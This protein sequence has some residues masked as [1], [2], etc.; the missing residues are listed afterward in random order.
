MVRLV[1]I[2][3]IHLSRRRAYFLDNWN[4]VVDHLAK[5]PP[6]LVVLTGDVSFNGSD[7]DDDL[8]FARAE[9][10]R[11]PCPTLVL[12]GN[13]DIGEHPLSGKNDQPIDT[14]RHGRWMRHFASDRFIVDVD[15]WTLIG[16][17]SELFGSGLTVE[18]EQWAWLE[19]E[20]AARTGHRMALFMHRPAF[21]L[22][23]GEAANYNSFIDP[24]PRL[25]LLNLVHKYRVRILAS[26]HLHAYRRLSH[27]GTDF[28]WAPG[29]SFVVANRRAELDVLNRSAILE[30]R[31]EAGGVN[32]FL[33]EPARLINLDFS[34]WFRG[35]ASTVQLPPLIAR[36]S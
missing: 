5:D 28:V 25:R 33:V 18:D 17:N 13:H 26:G 6:D 4:V 2:S 36:P 35:A 14:I 20:L 11:L 22:A 10:D 31:F 9:I 29:T 21:A 1:Q 8:A 23:P 27:A 12:P 34:N 30:W 3:D 19:S 16:L 7:E 24:V 15:G 32:H